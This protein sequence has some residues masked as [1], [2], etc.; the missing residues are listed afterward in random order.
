MAE[1]R[2]V[3]LR[4]AIDVPEDSEQAIVAATAELLQ[5]LLERNGLRPEDLISVIFTATPDL[6]AAFPAVA[7]RTLGLTD[8]PLLCAQELAVAGAPARVV[9]VLV[10][11]TSERS[12]AELQPVY[13]GGAKVLRDDLPG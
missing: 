6:G 7:A 13:L 10:H 4:G 12:R 11:C 5:A 8:V 2:V 9:R 3:A 1:R